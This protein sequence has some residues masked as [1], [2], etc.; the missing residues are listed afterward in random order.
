MPGEKIDFNVGKDT[1]RGSLNN[2]A[3]RLSTYSKNSGDIV[4]DNSNTFVRLES[5]ISGNLLLTCTGTNNK[6]KDPISGTPLLREGNA[7]R[8]VTPVSKNISRYSKNFYTTK[9][10]DITIQTLR[11][12]TTVNKYTNEKVG[13]AGTPTGMGKSLTAYK[14]AQDKLSY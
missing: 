12:T 2:T 9:D 4:I 7:V 6:V 1:Y 11:Q 10:I 13:T 3:T 5:P 14:G 8:P